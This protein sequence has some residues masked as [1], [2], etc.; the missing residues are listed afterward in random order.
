MSNLLDTRTN[1]RVDQ[2]F[3][4]H[5]TNFKKYGKEDEKL[6]K[7]L[8]IYMTLHSQKNL[9]GDID[10]DPMDFCKEMKVDRSDIFAKHPDPIFFRLRHE[11]TKKQ[12]ITLQEKNGNLSSSRIW[13]TKF[14]NALLIL[15]N[16]KFYFSE[17]NSNKDV[18]VVELKNYTYIKTL[19]IRFEKRNKTK[20]IIYIYQPTEEFEKTLYKLFLSVNL[21]N[22]IKLRSPSLEDLYLKLLYRIKNEN[23]KNNN[24]I[25]YNI[26][27]LAELMNIST[28]NINDKRGFSEVKSNINRKLKKYF[29][30]VNGTY[31]K[32]KFTSDFPTLNFTWE[33][34]TSTKKKIRYASVA[35]FSWDKINQQTIKENSN[36]IY[37]DIFYT[38]LL[39]ELSI[40]Y[41]DNYA[42][43]EI[44]KNK[45]TVN[46]LNWLFSKK[47]YNIK[48][49]KFI[50]VFSNIKGNRIDSRE[51]SVNFVSDLMTIGIF[52]EKH[53]FITYKNEL[54]YFH[55]KETDVIYEYKELKNL[56]YHITEN[57]NYFKKYYG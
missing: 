45:L 20:K 35:V 49:S 54:F 10:L 28:N 11:L 25:Y 36:K 47:D 38:K 33:K 18:T 57:I 16:E 6:I 22:Y 2:N 55:N 12:H 46:F 51:L 8:I 52:Q 27:E 19:K 50:S 29:F 17:E 39:Q 24:K 34:G 40:N 23:S 14:E 5:I 13:D 26:E 7:E 9:F 4:H 30:D 44:D 1:L 21:D 37:K 31:K 48:T 32:S 43:F 41:L 3:V 15:Q 56:I 42:R 53:Q